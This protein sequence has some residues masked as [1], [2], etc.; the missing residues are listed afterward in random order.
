MTD[1]IRRYPRYA[2]QLIADVDGLEIY[3]A[4]VSL[5]GIQIDCPGMRIHG[6]DSAVK[7]NCVVFKLSIPGGKPV[8]AAGRIAYKSPYGDDFLIGLEFV[9]FEAGTGA[10]WQHYIESLSGARPID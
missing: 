3:T 8:T 9:K 10:V 5:R 4:N 7:N 1:E 2:R 6:F